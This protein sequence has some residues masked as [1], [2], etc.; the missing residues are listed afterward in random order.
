MVDKLKT[1]EELTNIVKGLRI[2]GKRIVFTNG[3]FDLLHAGHVRYL[4]QARSMGDV[5]ILGLNSDSSVKGIKGESRPI[6][7]E[8]QRA[9]VLAALACVDFIV[10]FSAPDP[11]EVIRVLTPDILIKGSDWSEDQ[12]I[13]A[14]IVKEAG[15]RVER[16]SLVPGV[17]TSQILKRIVSR[18]CP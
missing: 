15:G 11:L 16:I 7:P 3:C 18:Y 13:G 14:D 4:Q 1:L 5:L 12:I 8:D 10:V 17:S 9:E 6:I 2:S